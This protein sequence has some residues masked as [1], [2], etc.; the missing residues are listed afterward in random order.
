[1]ST[2]I[3]ALGEVFRR[4]GWIAT[5]SPPSA[6]NSDFAFVAENDVAIVFAASTEPDL[7]VTDSSRLSSII[8]ASVLTVGGSKAWEAYLLLLVKGMTVDDDAAVTEVQ[9][10]LTYCRKVVVPTEGVLAS[11]DPIG[12]LSRRL[13]FLFPLSFTEM[14]RAEEPQQLL[15][16]GLVRR[17]NDRALVR[18]LLAGLSDPAFDPVAFLRPRLESTK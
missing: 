15:E 14:V 17:G 9:R 2:I 8:G 4:E 18:G 3:D 12:V 16:D 10:D 5:E 7:I 11:P 13:A 6:L 1:V